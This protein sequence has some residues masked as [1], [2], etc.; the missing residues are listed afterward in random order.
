[1]S[2]P[3]PWLPVP[4]NPC[5]QPGVP[6][7]RSPLLSVLHTYMDRPAAHTAFSLPA[8]FPDTLAGHGSH[9][10][11]D[12]VRNHCAAGHPD[13]PPH[14]RFYALP[15]ILRAREN[16]RHSGTGSG[17][18]VPARSLC[19]RGRNIPH[20][21]GNVPVPPG[22]GPRCHGFPGTLEHHPEQISPH[23]HPPAAVPAPPA[24]TA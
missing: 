14:N 10:L 7:V 19:R 3:G 24:A 15:A 20:R 16:F 21:R 4:S 8:V 1:M 12:I 18:A 6:A 5:R 17:Y 13:L 2:L 22:M 11:P 23:R 9:T